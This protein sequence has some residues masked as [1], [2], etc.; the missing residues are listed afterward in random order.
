MGKKYIITESQLALSVGAW[1]SYLALYG[2]VCGGFIG[3]MNLLG[4]GFAKVTDL[5]L[6]KAESDLNKKITSENQIIRKLFEDVG[7]GKGMKIE[8]CELQGKTAKCGMYCDD[9]RIGEITLTIKNAYYVVSKVKQI[10]L[11]S[12]VYLDCLDN[13]NN[14]VV[15][16]IFE[17]SP[18]KY[19]LTSGLEK[20]KKDFHCF[21]GVKLVNNKLYDY[22]T[23][24]LKFPIKEIDYNPDSNR[25][26]D[27]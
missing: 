25:N 10:K 15:L 7:K 11:K 5:V 19:F 6:K 1:L 8:I 12:D 18:K 9:N 4:L 27:Y 17:V 21:F 24:D 13:E 3:I 22:L 26:T 14:K 16:N 23:K 2:I 20:Y